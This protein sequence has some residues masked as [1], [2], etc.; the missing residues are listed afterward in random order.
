MNRANLK[1]VVMPWS[2]AAGLSFLAL[3]FAVFVFVPLV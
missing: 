3:L 2:A 1:S